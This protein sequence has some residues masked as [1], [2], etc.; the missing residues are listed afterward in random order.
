MKTRLIIFI[1]AVTLL[2][3]RKDNNP[4]IIDNSSNTKVFL[5]G[6]LYNGKKNVATL[7]KNNIS[8]DF[9][10]GVYNAYPTGMYVS[11]NDVYVAGSEAKGR[12]G[13]FEVATIWKNGTAIYLSDTN[14]TSHAYANAVF[15]SGFLQNR[16]TV[17]KNGVTTKL[18]ADSLISFANTVYVSGNDVYVGGSMSKAFLNAQQ[19]AVLW[20]NGIAI[21]LSDTISV[22]HS[23][24]VAGN[25]V[26]AAGQM[27]NGKSG[28]ATIWKNGV[29]QYLSSNN[30][31]AN[32]VAVVV[33][34]ND[35]YVAGNMYNGSNYIATVWKNGVPIFL[36]S[37]MNNANVSGLFILDKDVYVSG[38][39]NN[40]AK[41]WKNGVATEYKNSNTSYNCNVTAV[42]V[43]K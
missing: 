42:F 41:V 22:V 7:W 9:S 16:A 11:D 36:T 33:S 34:G 32:A 15:V 28:T 25:D 21:R 30:N 4:P 2:G 1:L 6:A 23:V 5:A 19:T 3:C 24:Y 38:T 39:E 37:G 18:T 31:D 14:N 17:W 29:P 26:Y 43:T 10:D 27:Y 8:A 35:V 12:G 40:T 20:K 13:L